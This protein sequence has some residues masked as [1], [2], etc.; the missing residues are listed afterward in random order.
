MIKVSRVDADGTSTRI[1]KRC[2]VREDPAIELVRSHEMIVCPHLGA[3][4]AS[5]GWLVIQFDVVSREPAIL[6]HCSLAYSALARLRIGMSGSAPFQSVR[7][8]SY[9]L[10][11]FALSPDKAY[12]LPSCR[13]AKAPTG[14]A[15]TMPR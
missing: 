14:S 12:A 3:E 11:A 15:S 8:P 4:I 5:S 10:F 6:I 13:C 2:A 9:A 1:C 7:K